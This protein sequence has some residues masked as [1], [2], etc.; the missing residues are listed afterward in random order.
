MDKHSDNFIKE[1]GKILS[2]SHRIK[3]PKTELK[4]TPK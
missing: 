1:N 4:N 2:R 3:N